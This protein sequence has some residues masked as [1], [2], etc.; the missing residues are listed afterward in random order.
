MSRDKFPPTRRIPW[1]LLMII[2]GLLV[3]SIAWMSPD[4]TPLT[5][6]RWIPLII[7]GG[8]FVALV[9]GALAFYRHRRTM[10]GLGYGTS[11]LRRVGGVIALL[12][13]AFFLSLWPIPFLQP[14]IHTALAIL[15]GL[16]AVI[17]G[18]GLV[19]T[20]SLDFRRAQKAYERGEDG[21]ALALL[22]AVEEEDPDF[23][24]T[25]HLRAVVHRQ[26]EHYEKAV[27]ACRRL[28]DLC[29]Q[30][31]YGHAELGM[32]LLKK[33]EPRR[34]IP[35]LKRALEIA[36]HLPQ[37]QFALGMAQAQDGESEEAIDAL[38]RALRMGLRNEVRQLL[39][40]YYLYQS[41]IQAGYKERALQ[42]KRRLRR[43]RRTFRRWLDGEDEQEH[44]LP[45]R[46]V[47]L[48]QENLRRLFSPD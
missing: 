12:L 38:S 21:R 23:C 4:I 33:G 36:P 20:T 46:Q 3:A 17:L 45:P 6:R 32:T 13:L 10:R 41:L 31:Y 29:P 1:E 7:Y 44:P 9:G 18:L 34:A 26:G 42:E 48:V 15:C 22:R 8:L 28:I 40:R 47:R 35:P 19:Q 39:A 5:W 24:P 2:G 14:W 30:L 27:K 16:A 37:A 25:Y 11:P 43:H